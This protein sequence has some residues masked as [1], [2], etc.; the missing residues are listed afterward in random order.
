MLRKVQRRLLLGAFL[1]VLAPPA[2]GQA[3]CSPSA[4]TATATGWR[5]FRQDS[6]A[7]AGRSFAEA[8][9]LCPRDLD[10]LNGMGYV[11]LRQ[12]RLA[13]ADSIF[14]SVTRAD[15]ASGDAWSGLAFTANRRGDT[16]TALSASRRAIALDPKNA[17][18]RRLL[19]QLEPDW[20]RVR[21]PPKARPGKLQVAA[22]TIGEHFE[23][24]SVQGWRRFYIRGVN[25][26]VAL[27]GR[28][29]SEFPPDS[30][31]YAG[32]LDTLAA[33]H[34]NTLR[35]YTILPPAFYRALRGWNL[36]HPRTPLW[37]VHGAWTEL[38]PADDFDDS[39]WKAQFRTEMRH[40]VDLLHGQ[41]DLPSRPGHASGRY[42]A[43]V[44]RWTLAY[45]L[46]REWE[47]FAVK[48]FDAK[49][50]GSSTYAGRFLATGRAP[51]MDVWMAT[52]CD[53]L[54]GYEVDRWNAIRPIAY[55]NWPTLD[56]LT[57]PTESTGQEE[58]AWR[59]KVG[60]PAGRETLEYDNDAIG[61]DAMLVHPT[62]ANPAGW[63]AS[64]H[65]Y[66]YYPDFLL[67]DP[68]YDTARGP[69]GRSNYFGYLRALQA[70]H[71]GLPLII[72]EYGVPSSRGVAHLQPQ[73]WT[74]GGHDEVAMAAIDAR[75]TREIHDAGLAGGMLFAWLD[76]WF[77]KNWVV[78][79]YEIPLEDTRQW[80]NMMDA[81]QNYGILAMLAGPEEATPVLGGDPG[82]WRALEALGPGRDA[83]NGQPSQLRI[84]SD[85]SYLYLAIEFPGLGGRPFPWDSLGVGL[86]L[87]SYEPALG[88]RRLPGGI[89]SA[90]GFEFLAQFES[91][92]RAGLRITPDYNPYIGRSA[93][94]DGDDFG[95]FARRPITITPRDDGKLDSLFVITNRSRFTRDGRF[96][97]ATGYD[98]GIL[99]FGTDAETTLA[100][101][102][103][104]AA[105]GLLELRLPW[106]LINVSDPSTGTL[107]FEKAA[108]PQIGTARS[109]GVRVGIY[110]WRKG[111]GKPVTALPDLSGDGRW[112][113]DEFSTWRWP[114]WTTPRWHQRL[115]PVYD[116]LRQLWSSP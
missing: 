19:D 34:A 39:T 107:L 22:R 66:P 15:S 109:D 42:D 53:Y 52:Q 89:E 14:R 111:D 70:H 32:W 47:P 55:T 49:H 101:W 77:K 83:T 57:H 24:P 20:D 74:H 54:L 60:R 27:P 69:E 90:I 106:N 68:G 99:R 46:G 73:G 4:A 62:A 98:R 85:E 71:Q 115:K 21:T 10:A 116:S 51:A 65:A 94:V 33:M 100:D 76:E 29:P 2:A 13:A 102:Y 50:P 86:A 35:V 63:F 43:D 61:L 64:F 40:V 48:A 7:G 11:A 112:Q 72:A 9:R 45:I 97:P 91:V 96:I 8:V 79:D 84:G 78:I 67:Y 114:T 80:H 75:L 82:R 95:R 25:L 113:A 12:G 36:G 30:S 81:E 58:S 59:S 88:Q 6:V 3:P 38:P 31:T 104:D 87:D 5:L 26:G 17:D 105:A 44:S 18:V 108:G 1:S 93:I 23:V 37:L 56:P 110:T 103:Y 16:A 92:E 41:A 28:F